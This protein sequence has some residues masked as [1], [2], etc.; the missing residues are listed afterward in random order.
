MIGLRKNGKL[1]QLFPN[2]Q[3]K[4]EDQNDPFNF[5]IIEPFISWPFEVPTEPNNELFNFPNSIDNPQKS[6]P[7]SPADVLLNGNTWKSGELEP[8]KSSDESILMNFKGRSGG[9]GSMKDKMIGELFSHEFSFSGTTKAYFDSVND[10]PKS[11][12]FFPTIQ[13]YGYPFLFNDFESTLSFKFPVFRLETIID[14]IFEQTGIRFI[15]EFDTSDGVFSK[16]VIFGNKVVDHSTPLNSSISLEDYM[17][18]I[19]LSELLAS[20]RAL[21]CAKGLISD[22]NDSISLKG[23]N[24]IINKPSVD[25][26]DNLVGKIESEKVNHSIGV[27]FSGSDNE[28]I[29]E[30]PHSGTYR[31]EVGNE[32]AL[33]TI[34]GPSIDDYA[35][36]LKENQYFEYVYDEVTSSYRWIP[37]QLPFQPVNPNAD[38]VLESKL[39]PVGKTRYHYMYPGAHY[40]PMPDLEFQLVDNGSGK[41]RIIAAD[42]SSGGSNI[43]PPFYVQLLDQDVYSPF[44]FYEITAVGSVN[45]KEA[46]LALDYIQDTTAKILIRKELDFFVPYIYEFPLAPR[47]FPNVYKTK[48]KTSYVMMHHGL[49]EEISSSNTYGYAS[50]DSINSKGN[51]VG[52]AA[53]RFH[54]K[55]SFYLKYWKNFDYFINHTRLIHGFLKFDINQLLSFDIY[56]KVRLKGVDFII[57]KIKS[58]VTSNSV[59]DQEFEGYRMP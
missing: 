37:G 35:F 41:V 48:T 22:S 23:F 6:F 39:N 15:N 7:S 5:E 42:S 25:Y 17:P 14:L 32:S 46:D 58:A 18:D 49:Q 16:F 50:S 44:V 12:V 57:K 2:Q 51:L 34:S 19:T 21:F 33:S 30:A 13:L 59:E 10:D 43:F 54:E 29:P 8:Y 38:S 52:P 36:C 56:K 11:P 26:S 53:I 45:G 27:Q 20:L 1:V 4:F 40:S 47:W 28:G 55:D 31:G 3:L 9:L 24:R